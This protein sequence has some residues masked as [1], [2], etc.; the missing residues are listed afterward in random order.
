MLLAKGT[1]PGVGASDMV[2]LNPTAASTNTTVDLSRGCG[3][4]SF[5]ADLASVETVPVTAT[6]PWIVDWQDITRD[7][8]NNPVT[9]PRIDGVTIGLFQGMTATDVQ[10]KILDIELIATSLWDLSV[11]GGKTA[12][13]SEARDRKTG[14]PFPGFAPARDATWM[15]A[16][17]CSSCQSPAPIVLTILQPR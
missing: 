14:V 5:S 10:A 11:A 16:L 4:L 13:L 17:T 7:G 3:L 12:D 9:Q 1:R 2:F 8:Q 6:G 15:L